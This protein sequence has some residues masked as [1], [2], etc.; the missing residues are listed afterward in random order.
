M[1]DL[2]EYNLIVGWKNIGNKTIFEGY[3][4][5]LFT[6]MTVRPEDRKATLFGSCSP[7]RRLIQLISLS[8]S[9]EEMN[10]RM[11][12]ASSSVKQVVLEDEDVRCVRAISH[13]IMHL[14]LYEIGEEEASHTW[15]RV[16]NFAE[17]SYLWAE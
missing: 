11:P 13:E 3:I 8:V 14:V 12:F 15:D 2:V 16:A 17:Y 7:E 6:K 10:R 1:V 9:K 5:D 4:I